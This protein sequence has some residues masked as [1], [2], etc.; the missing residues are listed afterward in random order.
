MCCLIQGCKRKKKSIFFHFSASTCSCFLYAQ[1][2]VLSKAARRSLLKNGFLK[3]F[4]V[5]SFLGFNFGEFTGGTSQF[6]MNFW[7]LEQIFAVKLIDFQLHKKWK[8]ERNF[9]NRWRF[10]VE[11]EQFVFIHQWLKYHCRRSDERF[12][13]I[14]TQSAQSARNAK[15][16]KTE[17]STRKLIFPFQHFSRLVKVIL[18]CCFPFWNGNKS[19]NCKNQLLWL[20]GFGSAMRHILGK[21][22]FISTQTEKIPSK[23]F[24]CKSRINNWHRTHEND[25][26]KQNR[27][28]NSFLKRF[29]SAFKGRI[30]R[31]FFCASCFST[32][33][34]VFPQRRKR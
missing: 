5:F 16:K 9:N 33:L 28:L 21:F 26:L 3:I 10:F 1:I 17:M 12:P 27:F 22:R 13:R 15:R 7:D 2:C 20:D 30:I 8:C 25:L 32:F 11:N 34:S 18:V 23:I 14:L 4:C 24:L 19:W 31:M 29:Q 6:G